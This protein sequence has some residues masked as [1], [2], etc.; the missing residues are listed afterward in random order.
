MLKLLTIKKKRYNNVIAL[1]YQ[2]VSLMKLPFFCSKLF[3]GG[4]GVTVSSETL[5]GYFHFCLERCH[6]F[7]CPKLKIVVNTLSYNTINKSLFKIVFFIVFLV[8]IFIIPNGMIVLNWLD[9]WK[10]FQ[11]NFEEFCGKNYSFC[12]PK[13]GEIIS[14]CRN[15]YFK[16]KP[17]TDEFI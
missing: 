6:R 13:H 2:R 12:L 9:K 4:G 5:W 17:E 8:T 14:A 7:G 16:K 10:D 3:A 15:Y 11:V 1:D